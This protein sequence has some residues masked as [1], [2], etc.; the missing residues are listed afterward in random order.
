VLITGPAGAGK[1]AAADR[2]AIQRTAPTAHIALDDVR[3]LVKAGYA[4]PADGWNAE[5]ARQLELAR[6]GCTELARLYVAAGIACMVDDAIFPDWPPAG[7][8]RWAEYLG[9]L[10]HALIVLLPSFEAVCQR[11]ALRV[12]RERLPED[13]LRVIYEMMLPWREQTRVPV[14]DNSHWS[15]DETAVRLQEA[16]RALGQEK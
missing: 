14:L 16:M 6:R 1:S 8:A 4:D 3:R 2:W 10:P 13:M 7:Y 5:T 9:A 15:L 11:N 12:G